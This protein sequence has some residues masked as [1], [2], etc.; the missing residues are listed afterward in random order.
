MP[1]AWKQ[2]LV[3][4]LL[5]GSQPSNWHASRTVMAGG[6]QNSSL[7]EEETFFFH[8]WQLTLI[9]WHERIAIGVYEWIKYDLCHHSW[10]ETAILGTYRHPCFSWLFVW[11]S[12]YALSYGRTLLLTGFCHLCKHDTRYP[13]RDWHARFSSLKPASCFLTDPKVLNCFIGSQIN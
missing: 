11:A 6:L 3:A 1:V 13:V 12:V 10:K 7:E 8:H 9:S 5:L 4:S 2:V